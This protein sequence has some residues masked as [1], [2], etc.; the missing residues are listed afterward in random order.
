MSQPLYFLLLAFEGKS[1]IGP[2]EQI[3]GAA[4]IIL[5]SY[6]FDL[7]SKRTGIP[8]VILLIGLGML[9]ARGLK[10]FLDINDL[11]G[12]VIP[13]INIL[14]TIGLILIVL[15]AALDLKLDKE[16]TGII[17]RSFIVAL[18]VL[19]LTALGVAY[20]LVYFLKIDFLPALVY[21]TPLSIMSSAIIIPSVG[22]L[23]VAKREFMIYEA[24][25]SDI[26]GIIMFFFLIGLDVE[27]VNLQKALS[28]QLFLITITI[29]GSIVVSYLLVYFITSISKK[30][31]FFTIFAILALIY[32]IGKLFHLSSLIT[33]LIFGLILNNVSVFFRGVL[34]QFLNQE[35]QERIVEDFKLLTHQSAFLVRTFFFVAFGLIIN[36]N[37][38]TD[39][40]VIIIATSILAVI[41]AVRFAH[42]RAV[43]AHDLIPELYIAPRGLI[44]VLL[45]FQIPEIYKLEQFNDGIMFFVIIATALVMM[46]SLIFYKP[47]YDIIE[48]RSVNSNQTIFGY[49]QDVSEIN[50][51]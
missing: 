11:S 29:L 18:L 34:S 49:G 22:E 30:A 45:F 25:F 4:L 47:K 33:I 37:S 38:L 19:V 48:D 2:Y 16:K 27:A 3:I 40:N 51:Q 39:T 1:G 6:S 15:E 13:V 32:A 23:S 7:I 21:A 36:I 5:L 42:L 31:N 44:T 10:Q 26:L 9:I 8:S 14:G 50:S 12:D 20:V 43:N 28:S 41:Y 24:T 17:V 35:Q 46:F